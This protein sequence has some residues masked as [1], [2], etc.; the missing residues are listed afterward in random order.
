[1]CLRLAFI[2]LALLPFGL[3]PTFEP[4]FLCAADTVLTGRVL[5]SRSQPLEVVHIAV[6]EDGQLLVEQNL[7]LGSG[8]LLNLTLPSVKA[9]QLSCQIKAPGFGTATGLAIVRGGQAQLGTIR[10]QPILEF[11]P[12]S[13]LESASDGN[14]VIDFWMTSRV[15]RTLQVR[16]LRI[17]AEEPPRGPCFES[18]PLLTLSFSQLA[19]TNVSPAAGEKQLR[20]VITVQPKGAEASAGSFRVEGLLRRNPCGPTLV[21]LTAP[22][23][24]AIEASEKGHPLKLRV[25]VPLELRLD[26]NTKVEPKWGRVLVQVVLDNGD[27]VATQPPG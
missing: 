2:V 12:V 24:F 23:S 5:D 4:V 6:F 15:P 22:Y 21:R 9:D 20:A 14:A 10:L 8:G 18:A 26:R 13:V 17:S 16:E 25:E 19:T 1:M 3:F 11:G 7:E 27:I